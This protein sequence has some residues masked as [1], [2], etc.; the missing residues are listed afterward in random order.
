MDRSRRQLLAA[1]TGTAAYSLAGCAELLAGGTN[2]ATP[3]PVT[4]IDRDEAEVPPADCG[5]ADQ[6]LS[7]RLTNV[8]G[9]ED[10]CFKGAT[11][12]LVIENER[13]ESVDLDVDLGEQ[14][15]DEYTIAA[16]DRRYESNAFEATADIEGR[17]TIDGDDWELVWA[18]R[19]CY[20][21]GI[22]ITSEGPVIGWVKPIT[23]P[24]DTQHDCY[25]GASIPLTIGSEAGAWTVSATIRDTCSDST[26]DRTVTLEDDEHERIDD[27]L[28]SGGAYEVTIDVADGETE[29]IS[30]DAVCWGVTASIRSDGTVRLDQQAID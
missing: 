24:G 28:T 9:N 7:E 2:E 26:D 16:G 11:P 22:A 12:S 14:F 30:F 23:G 25:P 6:P 1:A 27:L 15:A 17:V 8:S 18:D 5:P 29:K 3:N 19:S 4:P 10:A 13:D 21:Y 20:R